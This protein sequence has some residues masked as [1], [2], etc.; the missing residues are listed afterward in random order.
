[1]CGHSLICKKIKTLVL[2]LVMLA[3]FQ[4]YLA[5]CECMCVVLHYS[6]TLILL[7]LLFNRLVHYVYVSFPKQIQ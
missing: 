5:L 2:A 7:F 6:A 1:M 3:F 4:I